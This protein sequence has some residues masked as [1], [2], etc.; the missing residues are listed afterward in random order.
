[1][2]A[3]RSLFYYF[4]IQNSG[5][6]T[7]KSYHKYINLNIDNLLRIFTSMQRP[8]IESQAAIKHQIVRLKCAEVTSIIL[9][10]CLVL[11]FKPV[12]Y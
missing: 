1:V 8:I 4:R 9:G 7:R 10:E 3:F 12:F 11:R 2:S 5:K 6:I